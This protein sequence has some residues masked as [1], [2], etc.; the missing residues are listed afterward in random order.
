M[1]NW[2]RYGIHTAS[3]SYRPNGKK[4]EKWAPNRDFCFLTWLTPSTAGME[5]TAK[6]KSLSSMHT[7]QSSRGVATVFP[8]PPIL[9]K[10]RSP[11]YSSTAPTSLFDILGIREGVQN[12][13]KV[14]GL[15]RCTH[16]AVRSVGDDTSPRK[17]RQTKAKTEA[18]LG[19][20]LSLRGLITW[21]ENGIHAAY[22]GSS[23]RDK[24]PVEPHPRF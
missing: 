5:S 22:P 9:V 20:A 6:T 23:R 18:I 21:N 19:P 17:H 10:K 7:K 16:T 14:L 3:S 24:P 13:R 2:R 8:L 15:T 1:T 11:S 4:W 12:K